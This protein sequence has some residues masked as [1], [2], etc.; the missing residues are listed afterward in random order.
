MNRPKLYINNIEIEYVDQFNLLGIVINKNLNWIY[1]VDM[2]SKKIAKTV[3]I[4]H[5][6]KYYLPQNALYNIYN[7]LIL[8]HLNY[9]NMIWGHQSG[10]LFTIKKKT[11]RCICLAKYHVH[12]SPLFK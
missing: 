8:S 1:H 9:G 4:L 12:T 6:L 7:A 3:G 5:Q 2:I 11:V 10:R